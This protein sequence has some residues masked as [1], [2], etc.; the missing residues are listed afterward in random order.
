MRDFEF[1]L[2][3]PPL[4]KMPLP[5]VCGGSTLHVWHPDSP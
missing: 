5:S 1:G 4:I 2:D 3:R